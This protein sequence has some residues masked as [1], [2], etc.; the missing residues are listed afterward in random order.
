MEPRMDFPFSN[1]N[2]DTTT[3]SLV[4]HWQCFAIIITWDLT[5]QNITFGKKH[6]NW[7]SFN[8]HEY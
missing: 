8:S 7:A 1:Q 5:N 4:A 6:I 2:S 3:V